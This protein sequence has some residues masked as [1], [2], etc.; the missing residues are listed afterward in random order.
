M[1]R[2][3][4]GW[5]PRTRLRPRQIAGWRNSWWETG[6]ICF[7]KMWVASWHRHA[8]QQSIRKRATTLPRLLDIVSEPMRHHGRPYRLNVFGQYHV[9]PVH[10]GPGLRCMKQSQTCARRQTAA[11][12]LSRS[13]Q[14]ILEI[15][16]QRR[17]GMDRAHFCLDLE[18]CFRVK[19]WIQFLEHLAPIHPEKHRPLACA[20]RHAQFDP[21][22]K[23]IQLRFGQW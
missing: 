23:P 3:Y 21:H 5:R 15:I 7:W 16:E 14:Q 13:V 17:R 1:T 2:R 12:A 11:M 19:N 6:E 20:V 9:A 4:F 18:Q 8:V 10:H 22:Q